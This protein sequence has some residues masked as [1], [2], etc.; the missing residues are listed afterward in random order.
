MAN[1]TMEI[2]AGISQAMSQS[3]DG[4]VDENDKPVKIG[5]KRE[6]EIPITDRRV[7]DGFGVTFQGGEILRIKYHGECTL[8]EVS[9]KS[10]EGDMKQML[11]DISSWLKKEYRKVTGSSLS[12]KKEGKP[13]IDVQTVGRHRS[14]VQAF[15]DYKLSLDG[16]EGPG[17]NTEHKVDSAIRKMLAKGGHDVKQRGREDKRDGRKK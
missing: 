7:M 8:E 4:A 14:W 2:M 13:D 17:D 11:A 16:A 9:D 12:L 1:N 10:F 6:K 15:Q 5:L 3:Y